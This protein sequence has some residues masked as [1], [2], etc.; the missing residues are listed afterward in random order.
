MVETIAASQRPSEIEA[1]A[2]RRLANDSP[3]NSLN[4]SQ[5]DTA[6]APSPM[7]GQAMS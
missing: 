2:L 4:R 3:C 5:D 7:T 1:N 6:T